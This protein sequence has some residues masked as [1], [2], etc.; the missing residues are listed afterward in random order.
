M[1]RTRTGISLLAQASRTAAT[2]GR[3]A[4]VS[5]SLMVGMPAFASAPIALPAA[6][7]ARLKDA[8]A[9]PHRRALPATLKEPTLRSD[10][11]VDVYVEDSMGRRVRRTVY[12]VHWVPNHPARRAWTHARTSDMFAW[13]RRTVECGD[14][15]K[16]FEFAKDRSAYPRRIHDFGSRVDGYNVLE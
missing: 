13:Q 12:E 2:R 16:G 3:N 15:L 10:A 4:L 9:T 7:S 14:M 8:F 1:R 11:N 6:S 5:F